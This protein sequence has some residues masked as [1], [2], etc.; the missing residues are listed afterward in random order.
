M[1][2]EIMDIF[3]GTD[4]ALTKL[5]RAGKA[6]Q[7]FA[8][9]PKTAGLY[10]VPPPGAEH[11]TGFGFKSLKRGLKKAGR[12][13]KKAGKAGYN[14]NKR[15]VKTSIKISVAP[16]KVAAKAGKFA[17]RAMAK[18]AAKPIIYVVNKLAGRRA[19]Y[20]AFQK[21][22]TTVTT[23]T[24]KKAGGQYALQKLGKAGPVGKLAVKILKF[25]GGVTAGD[26]LSGV[27]NDASC[28][29]WEADAAACGM[30][31]AEIAAAAMT[32]VAATTKLMKSL[33]KPG[34]APAN[35]KAAT[36]LQDVTTET[37]P[38]IESTDEPAAEEPAAEE[39]AAEDETEGVL[40]RMTLEEQIAYV[41]ENQP[42]NHAL[43]KK[44]AAKWRRLHPKDDTLGADNREI[45]A[46]QV[47]R[48]LR[49]RR[50]KR[51]LVRLAKRRGIPVPPP[52]PPHPGLRKG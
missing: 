44:L 20:L 21:R 42:N 14:L 27:V 52:P 30:T 34:E 12:G 22:G 16:I 33:N 36:T 6:T 17:L 18:L 10:D 28:C 29:G 25:T 13:V 41:Q 47:R 39:P 4:K 31:G 2:F 19:K 40:G 32:I 51:A 43:L 48:K 24:D 38:V 49:R 8:T 11:L 37:E 35:P 46:G 9:R 7:R 45:I 26:E 23:L 3:K 1:G 50:L 5:Q 15:V